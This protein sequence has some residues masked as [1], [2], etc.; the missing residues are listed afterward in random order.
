MHGGRRNNRRASPPL[1]AR[2][3]R[4]DI[5]ASAASRL[6]LNFICFLAK[7]RAPV[8]ERYGYVT[9][10]AVITMSRLVLDAGPPRS[11]VVVS[12]AGELWISLRN[13]FLDFVRPALNKGVQISLVMGVVL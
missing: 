7:R 6:K 9:S 2:S 12:G 1:R 3:R 13:C 5:D 11:R 8:R 10:A 4:L